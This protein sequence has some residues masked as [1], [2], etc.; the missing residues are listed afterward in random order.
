MKL[1][2]NKWYYLYGSLIKTSKKLL[3]ILKV[4]W[5]KFE[6]KD[7]EKN[8]FRFIRPMKNNLRFKNPCKSE[9]QTY[10]GHLDV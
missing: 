6:K 7:K 1:N 3:V 4:G 8:M 9:F 5:P 10:Y 2:I